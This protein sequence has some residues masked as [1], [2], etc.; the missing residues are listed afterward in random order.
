MIIKIERKFNGREYLLV[1]T[2]SLRITKNLLIS[3]FESSGY[4]VSFLEVTSPSPPK[5]DVAVYDGNDNCYF[6]KSNGVN[7][8]EHCV[9]KGRDEIIPLF[10]EGEE[11]YVEEDDYDDEFDDDE[12]D[13]DD[14]Y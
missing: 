12:F 3:A 6:W 4:K 14:D 11:E 2:L 8:L 13:D 1:S 7:N 9:Y 5:Y 10:V